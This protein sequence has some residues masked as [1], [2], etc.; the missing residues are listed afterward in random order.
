MTLDAEP[1]AKN[2]RLKYL[3]ERAEQQLMLVRRLCDPDNREESISYFGRVQLKDA[4]H[5]LLDAIR[6]IVQASTG[7]Y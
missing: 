7:M 1:I 2:F 4:L 6:N 5:Q 3:G